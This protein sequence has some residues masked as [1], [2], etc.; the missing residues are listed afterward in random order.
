MNSHY[1]NTQYPENIAF[2]LFALMA[3]VFCVK[4]VRLFL[5]KVELN[6]VIF[7]GVYFH[8]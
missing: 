7:E 5:S 3:L 2:I 8:F 4:Q 6:L 1:K